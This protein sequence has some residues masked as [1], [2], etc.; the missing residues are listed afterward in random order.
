MWQSPGTLYQIAVQ[1]LT[2]CREI[3]TSVL[4]TSSE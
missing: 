2:L 1:Y 3:P 4:W